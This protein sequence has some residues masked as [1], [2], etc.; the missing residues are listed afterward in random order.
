MGHLYAAK[1]APDLS[2]V[3]WWASFQDIADC[4]PPNK[5]EWIIVM[6]LDRA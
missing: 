5:F 1:I 4:G 3:A 2:R 6:H